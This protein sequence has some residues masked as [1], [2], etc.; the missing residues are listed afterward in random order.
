MC[1]LKS[2]TVDLVTAY[3]FEICSGEFNNIHQHH[4]DTGAV[5]MPRP[6]QILKDFLFS[7]ASPSRSVR[8]NGV[9]TI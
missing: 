6:A 8:G 2:P 9:L 4:A 7:A 1:R 5:F 3:V